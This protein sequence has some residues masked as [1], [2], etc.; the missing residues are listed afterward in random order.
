MWSNLIITALISVFVAIAVLG[1]VLVITALL[2]KPHGAKPAE[3][4]KEPAESK[5]TRPA[6]TGL[7]RRAVS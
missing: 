7:P 6:G 1:H 2:S 5:D 4:S 3:D